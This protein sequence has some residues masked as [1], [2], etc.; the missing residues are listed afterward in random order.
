MVGPHVIADGV[1]H[2]VVG[3]SPGDEPTLAANDLGH[4][5]LL[6]FMLFSHRSLA[7]RALR[8]A[9]LS[10]G[11]PPTF[12]LEPVCCEDIGVTLVRVRIQLC[13]PLAIEYDGRRVESELPGRQG[14]LAFMF[15]V[16]HRHREVMREELVDALW[17]REAPP[18]VDGALNALLSKIRRALGAD[19]LPSRGALRLTLDARVDL[20]DARDAVHR[21][22][23]AI[24]QGDHA[25]AWGPSQVALFTAERGFAPGDDAPW[26][27][28]VRH[29]LNEIRLRALETYGC[30]S[31][32]IGGAE[33]AA[34]RRAGRELVRIAPLR[35]SGYRLLM[36]ALAR[37]GNG[38]EALRVYDTLCATLRDQIGVAPSV[39][40][41]ELHAHL[42]RA[43]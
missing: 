9:V 39:A 7:R 30:A 28:D 6:L 4:A 20:E 11:N 38:A 32:G 40:T 21:A 37:E 35:E 3:R 14:R 34:A 15:L 12:V 27:D 36:E 22:E 19:A 5:V 1:Y 26:I 18:A 2:L 23:S 42:L 43:Q 41:R 24:A 10:P 16:L 13:G 31:L 25:R 17:P 33:L 8:H 29:E